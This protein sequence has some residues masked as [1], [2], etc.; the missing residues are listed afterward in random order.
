MARLNDEEYIENDG[1]FCDNNRRNTVTAKID[2]L[3]ANELGLKEDVLQL[4]NHV[5]ELY[6]HWKTHP[7]EFCVDYD[8]RNKRRQTLL[9][10]TQTMPPKRDEF[11]TTKEIEILDLREHTDWFINNNAD[12][13]IR[14]T[15]EETFK[16]AVNNQPRVWFLFLKFISNSLHY[17]DLH[18]GKQEN[19]IENLRS[20]NEELSSGLNT[21]TN[22]KKTRYRNEILRLR[23]EID[24]VSEE[25]DRLRSAK[26]IDEVDTSKHGFHKPPDKI[27]VFDG[28]FRERYDEWV[29]K[30]LGQIKT[31][32]DWF[33]NEDRK[34]TYLMRHLT[35]SPYNLLKDKYDERAPELD[36]AFRARNVRL[37][38]KTNLETL[39]MGNNQSFDKMDELKSRL[40]TRFASR[41]ILGRRE[42]YDELVDHCYTLDSELGMYEAKK[43]SESSKDPRKLPDFP[44]SNGKPHLDHTTIELGKSSKP[45]SEMSLKELKD[46]RNS[47]PRSAVIKQRLLNENRCHRCMQKGHTGLDQVCQFNRL[48]QTE[49]FKQK[50]FLNSISTSDEG[51]GST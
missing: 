30:F 7:E 24:I 26:H 17:A 6:D 34:L 42:T 50:S 43:T 33:I 45:L 5:C 9:S 1:M 27:D 2:N 35:G 37:D 21:L 51:N 38:A 14:F 13:N 47:L 20:S 4:A 8:L 40:N 23:K 48:P 10:L 41:I 19:E 22:E 49:K 15:S 44:L 36:R 28:K 18:I 29:D 16:E 12:L 11:Q 32:S 3:P 39:R 25:R 31:Y 46:Y